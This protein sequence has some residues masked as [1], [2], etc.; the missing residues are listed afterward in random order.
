MPSNWTKGLLAGVLVVAAGSTARSEPLITHPALAPEGEYWNARMGRF[1]ESLVR[2]L[3][4]V[5]GLAVFD[6]NIGGHGIDG[7]VRLTGSDG[8]P[9]YRVIEVKA[10]QTGTDFPLNDTRADFRVV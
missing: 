10:L 5:R 6:L 3:H 7:L 2:E 8:L 4:R 9:E 1:G